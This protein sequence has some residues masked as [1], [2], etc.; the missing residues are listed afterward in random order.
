MKRFLG[1]VILLAIILFASS[2]LIRY[3]TND[4]FSNQGWP[5]SYRKLLIPANSNGLSLPLCSGAK[6]PNYLGAE[7]KADLPINRARLVS[8]FIF[9]LAIS[10][11]VLS[12]AYWVT[13]K[14]KI[15]S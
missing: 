11:I 1:L 9:W 12:S 13:G 15:K 5:L 7:C 6:L 2:S 10:F 3:S 14:R 4:G 8:D